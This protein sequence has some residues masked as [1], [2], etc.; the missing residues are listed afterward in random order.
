MNCQMLLDNR[1]QGLSD[2]GHQGFIE[3][4]R[5]R[6][7]VWR[8]VGGRWQVVWRAPAEK[9]YAVLDDAGLVWGYLNGYADSEMTV[10]VSPPTDPDLP[11]LY[12]AIIAQQIEKV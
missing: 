4:T 8:V 7:M 5:D 12:E 6:R 2:H 1:E 10:W 11:D 3:Q 9:C